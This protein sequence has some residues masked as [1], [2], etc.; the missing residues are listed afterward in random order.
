MFPIETMKQRTLGERFSPY[1]TKNKNL[2]VSPTGE[3]GTYLQSRMGG[4]SQAKISS[5]GK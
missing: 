3:L 4:P 2:A 1:G 5:G